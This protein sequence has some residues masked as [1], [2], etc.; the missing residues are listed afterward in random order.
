MIQTEAQTFQ[1]SLFL[2][3]HPHIH[4]LS[5]IFHHN[6]AES[7]PDQIVSGVM[8]HHRLDDH[9][10]DHLGRQVQ[11]R[12]SVPQAHVQRLANQLHHVSVLVTVV[13]FVVDVVHV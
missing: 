10:V 1:V 8:G 3:I 6:L 2:I 5:I 4:S 12:E 7:L 11:R 13:V 9:G